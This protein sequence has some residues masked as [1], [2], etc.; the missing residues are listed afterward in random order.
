MSEYHP[1]IHGKIILGVQFKAECSA[2]GW[3]LV[4]DKIAVGDTLPPDT[5]PCPRCLLMQQW[6][7]VKV[8]RA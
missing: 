3:N 5:I 4:I 2:C 1:E 8:V 6:E 7:T